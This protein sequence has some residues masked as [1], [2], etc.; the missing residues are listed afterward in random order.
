MKIIKLVAGIALG[1]LIAGTTVTAQESKEGKKG[2]RPAGKGPPTVEKQLENMT[3][4]LSLTDEQKP[5][6]K[7]VIEENRKKME[8]LYSQAGGDREKMREL[9][10]KRKEI[11]DEQD[12]KLKEILKSDQYE[13]WEKMRDK[14]RK[15]GRKGGAGAEGEK[16]KD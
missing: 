5:K 8:E 13:K 4:E 14:M 6:V 12:K 3:K 7:A 10:G 2:D 9:R 16:K 1:A 11:G 15:G